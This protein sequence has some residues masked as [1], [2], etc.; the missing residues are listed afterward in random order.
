[1][2]HTTDGNMLAADN[3]YNQTTVEDEAQ[4]I[5][6][7]LSEFEISDLIED[8]KETDENFNSLDPNESVFAYIVENIDNFT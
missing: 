3:F 2:W 1:M 4:E 5:L 8:L 6:E 7:S